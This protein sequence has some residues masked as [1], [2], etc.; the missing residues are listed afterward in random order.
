MSGVARVQCP[1]QFCK[2]ISV[3]VPAARLADPF[4]RILAHFIAELAIIAQLLQTLRYGSG[5]AN[6]NNKSLTALFNEIFTCSINRANYRATARHCLA[7]NHSKAVLYAWQH[8]H[9]T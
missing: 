4:Q 7:E 8:R 1:T 2:L 3:I 6:G 5:I 9:V